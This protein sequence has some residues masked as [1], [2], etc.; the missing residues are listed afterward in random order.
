MHNDFI[1]AQRLPVAKKYKQPKPNDLIELSN[2]SLPKIHATEAKCE[3]TLTMR[4]GARV[5]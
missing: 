5:I 1:R 4:V 3:S 2:I